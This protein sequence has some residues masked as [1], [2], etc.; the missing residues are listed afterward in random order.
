MLLIIATCLSAGPWPAM[1]IWTAG[2]LQRDGQSKQAMMESVPVLQL[3][4]LWRSATYQ[5]WRAPD[6]CFAY[7]GHLG[8]A[9]VSDT[10]MQSSGLPGRATLAG[11]MNNFCL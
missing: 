10:R 2:S 3:A 5:S 8:V 1:A 9:R 6:T 7:Q 4:P 11:E